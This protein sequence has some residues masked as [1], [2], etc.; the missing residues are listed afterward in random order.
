MKILNLYAGIGGNRKLWGNNHEIT[1]VEYDPEIAKIYNDFFPQD[2][3]IVDDAHQYLLKNYKYY[4]FI[5]SSPPCPTHSKI[6]QC[7]VYSGQYDA[8]YPEMDLY[9]QIILLK[10]FNKGFY[11]IENVIP[12]YKPLIPPSIELHRHYFWSNFPIEKKY[13]KDDRKHNDIK[14]NDS[15]Y[16]FELK[17]YDYK[18]KKNYYGIW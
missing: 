9:Q 10:Y 11:V 1:A 6:R 15:I 2:K 4:D 5:W 8:K 7:G 12:Y 3:I 18:E 16:G 14:T 17:N 13:F